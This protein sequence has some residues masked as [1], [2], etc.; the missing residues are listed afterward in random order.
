MKHGQ[1]D[2]EEELVGLLLD[3]QQALL[4]QDQ[5]QGSI[6]S[7]LPDRLLEFIVLLLSDNQLLS[8]TMEGEAMD[9]EEDF[10]LDLLVSLM[11]VDIILVRLVI[12]MDTAM[13]LDTIL[14]LQL[15]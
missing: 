13:V 3:H 1:Q 5:V 8:I 7:L 6:V 12:L 2:L 14:L 9:M 10:I 4:I 11:V 15:A